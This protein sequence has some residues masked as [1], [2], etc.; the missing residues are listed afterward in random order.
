[1][2]LTFFFFFLN[3]YFTSAKWTGKDAFSPAV[4]E[5]ATGSHKMKKGYYEKK[6]MNKVL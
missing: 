2:G 4:Y 3:F 5:Y 1:M 6:E